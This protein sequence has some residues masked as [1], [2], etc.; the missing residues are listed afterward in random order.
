MRTLSVV[1]SLLVFLAVASAAEIKVKVL[2][3][4]SAAVSGAEV[5]LLEKGRSAP[6]DVATTAAE[7]VAL[8]RDTT[9]GEY[10]VRVLAPG[11]APEEVSLPASQSEVTVKLRLAT[12]AETVV[13]SGT[14]SPVPEEEAGANVSTL[15]SDRL[16]LMHPVAAGDAVRFL[17]GAVVNTNGRR[18]GLTSLFVRGGDSRYNK[19]IVDGVP[20]T[21]PGGTFDF[22]VVP[23][24][25]VDRLELLRGAQ[26]TLYGSDAMTSVVQVWTRVGSTQVPELRFGADGGNFGTAEG[27]LSLSGAHAAYDY[28]LFGDQFNSNGQGINDQYSNSSQGANLGV[29]FNPRA[30]LRF[31]IRHS[32]N[33][34]GVQSFWNFDGQPLIPPDSDQWARQNNLLASIELSLFSGSRWQHHFSGFEYNHK[35]RNVDTFSDPGRVS[36]LDTRF[37]AV[38]DIN[39]AGFDYQG[40]YWARSWAQSTLGYEFEDENGSVGTLPDALSHGLLRNH[41]AYGQQVLLAGRLSL[42]TGARFVH[43]ESFGNKLVPRVALSLLTHR[44]GQFF[45]GTRLRFAYATGIKEPSFSESFGNGGGFP[46]LPNSSLRP[47][48][49]RSL[50][51]GLQQKISANY[52]LSATYFNNLFRN[53]ID[54]NFLGC[55]PVCAG[56]FVNVNEALAHGAE[57]EFHGRPWSRLSVDS[58]YNYNS[59]Q[60]LRAPLAFDPLL[61]P[62]KPL[63][64]RP[65]HSG[66]L[67]L[68]YLGS[69]WGG[70]LGGTFVGRRTDSDFLGFGINHAAG[71][72]R[73]DL[74]GWYAVNSRMTAYLNLENALNKH[75]EEVAG[76]PALRANFRAGVRFRIGGE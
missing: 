65:R 49:T 21:D 50:E 13:V 7:G 38:T 8:V 44:G 39:R 54:F 66:S 42:V 43:N 12:A 31:R 67:L 59:T 5:I 19:V 48:E 74:G 34:S 68:A 41:A 47:E 57:L 33:R 29:Q 17:P 62:G 6:V 30:L 25:Q 9:A 73:L 1:L 76:Y 20:I 51:A 69:R 63:L 72:A 23:L 75:Y 56:Q 40:I 16:Q 64:R 4:Q 2:D 71:Y 37:D 14:R 27:Y 60:I 32:N 24:Q 53:K 15:D 58:A 52:S 11:F 3:P 36:P 28:N 18:G 35:R 46:V 26:S 70:N 10:L 55:N 61:G 45:S 22:G